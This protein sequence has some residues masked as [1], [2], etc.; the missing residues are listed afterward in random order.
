MGRSMLSGF[1]ATLVLPTPHDP[2]GDHDYD[3]LKPAARDRA[4]RSGCVCP[5]RT[6]P[7]NSNRSDVAEHSSAGALGP[8]P[9]LQVDALA[10]GRA[11]LPLS[12][13][14][15]HVRG[16]FRA[17]AWRVG[18]KLDGDGAHLPVC[19]VGR[20]RLGSGA[21]RGEDKLVVAAVALWRLE[22]RLSR[23]AERTGARAMI[24]T[25]ARPLAVIAA[26]GW[27][28]SVLVSALGLAGT[29]IPKM[30]TWVIFVGVFPLWF[31]AILLMNKLAVNVTSGDMWKAV[32]RG[33]PKWLRYAIQASWYYTFLMFLFGMVFGFEG[34]AVAGFPGVFYANALGAFVTSATVAG[35]PTECSNGH[36]IGPF[37]KFCREC[38]AAIP[39]ST[40]SSEDND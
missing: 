27:A 9:T 25:F 37:D 20:P 21:T 16:G 6:Q 11:R 30:A 24:A 5:G 4:R 17:R 34:G 1:C 18:R 26:I 10:P 38:G 33:C 31:F 2:H 15:L 32:L 14:V 23:A 40:S 35:E 22:R 36:P 13:D 29:P 19:A 7:Q 3:L 39:R 8:H 12:A 28:A